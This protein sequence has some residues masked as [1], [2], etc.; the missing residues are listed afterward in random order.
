MNKIVFIS[1]IFCFLGTSFGATR[2][3]FMPGNQNIM[4]NITEIGSN[5][6]G[7]RDFDTI[8]QALQLPV[9]ENAFLGRGKGFKLARNEFSISCAEGRR[10][11]SLVLSRSRFLT[12]RPQ[13]QTFEFVMQA[14]DSPE[15]SH[16]FPNP[17]NFK[18]EDRLLE[19]Q[20]SDQSFIMRSPA[21]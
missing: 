8:Y 2:I 21:R 13:A 6:I 3:Q 15:L 19:I 20:S 16:I 14:P 1:F 5:G 11:C 9:Q 4:I 18:S 12:S 7:D 10:Q 17:F